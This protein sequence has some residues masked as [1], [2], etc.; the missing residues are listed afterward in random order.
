VV[1]RRSRPVVLTGRTTFSAAGNFVAEVEQFTRARL[2]GEPPGGS[3]NQWGDFA[4]VAL[5]NVGLEV[6]VATVYVERGRTGDTSPAI[7]PHVRV[8]ASS[9]DWLAGRDPVLQAALR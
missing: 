6:M 5:P 9:A 7:E 3:A 2:V 8:E 4:P 1:T